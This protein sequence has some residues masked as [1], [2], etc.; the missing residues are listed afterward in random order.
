L[1]GSHVRSPE[2]TCSMSPRGD[3]EQVLS[4]DRTWEPTKVYQRGRHHAAIRPVTAPLRAEQVGRDVD[5][6]EL[7]V[8]ARVMRHDRPE[9]N[10][11]SSD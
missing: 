1:V 10:P 6:A 3:I 9:Y 8:A 4:G 11:D 7:A 5:E 2:R